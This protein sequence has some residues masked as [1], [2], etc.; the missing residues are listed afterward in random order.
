MRC[1]QNWSEACEKA[2]NEQI[3]REY[4]AIYLII[5]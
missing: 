4:S 3:G 2:L 5:F 1:R